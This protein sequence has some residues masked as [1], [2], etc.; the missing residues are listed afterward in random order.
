LSSQVGMIAVVV[1]TRNR[2]QLLQRCVGAVLGQTRPPG[3]VVVVDNASAD[4]T[5]TLFQEGP[6]AADPRI[7]FLRLPDNSGGA[8]GFHAGMA[9]AL[10]RG[11]Q[12]V[13]VMD[14]DACPDADALAALL[15]VGPRPDAIYG[16]AVLAD[17]GDAGELVWPV[18]PLD[19]GSPGQ[20]ALRNADLPWL[21]VPT[22][23]VP[24]LGLLVHRD[25]IERIGLP[26]AEF[27]LSGDDAEF[28]ARAR[29][30]GG[31]V[32]V[33]PA[34]VIRHPPVP[35]LCLRIGARVVCVLRLAPWRR[36]YDVRNRLI[37]AR[38]YF[39]VRLWTEALPGTL[40]RWLLT[41]ILQPNRLAQSRAYV[42]GIR[43][44]LAG[45]TGRLWPP[46]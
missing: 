12:W 30:R 15:A 8:G 10:A 42:K 11:A 28:C 20:T 6:F 1:V 38:R 19:G 35:R 2:M 22:A 16:A 45:R 32:F 43:D 21:P 9:R 40:L 29:A 31:A 44:G 24:F 37:I 34:A 39:G 14:D 25:L 23:N 36:Y 13:W 5:P 18:Q 41:L 4:A 46:P 33:V 3:L 27:F 26:D 17:E 7:D